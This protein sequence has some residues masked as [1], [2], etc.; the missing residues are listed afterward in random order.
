[1]CKKQYPK[2]VPDQAYNAIIKFTS[3][4][5]VDSVFD[6]FTGADFDYFRDFEENK[7]LSLKEGLT[8]LYEAIAYPIQHDNM[9][10]EEAK[11]IVNVF[12]DFDIIT[13]DEEA[14]WL[15]AIDNEEE[16]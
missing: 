5:K 6:I 15:L 7:I 8:L 3:H 1:M 14:D 4:L 9:T 11:L 10:E 13:T 2:R 12:K 16:E